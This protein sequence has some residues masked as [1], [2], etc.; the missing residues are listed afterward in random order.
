MRRYIFFLASYLYIVRTYCLVRDGR[1]FRDEYHS[2]TRDCNFGNT[3]CSLVW[4]PKCL[5]FGSFSRH[6]LH[7]FQLADPNREFCTVATFSF[8]TDWNTAYR[9]F[10]F[11]MTSSRN[12]LQCLLNYIRKLKCETLTVAQSSSVR[13]FKSTRN[14]RPL[15]PSHLNRFTPN[16]PYMGR[17]APLTSKRCILYIYSTN[18]GTQYFKRALYSPFFSLQNAVCFIMLTC[19]VP[20]LIT[21]YI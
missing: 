10:T 11:G 2:R 13:V 21:F 12:Q 17:T 8:V 15:V 6:M 9:F 3:F 7:A 16:D 14:I 1:L 19:F 4:I 20:A 5:V 18:K